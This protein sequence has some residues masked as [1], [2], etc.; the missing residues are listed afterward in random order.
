VASWC[1]RF[2]T[3]FWHGDGDMLEVETMG[4]QPGPDLPLA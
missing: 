4:F 3:R 1:G 2:G